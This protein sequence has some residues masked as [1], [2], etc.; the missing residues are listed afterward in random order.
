MFLWHLVQLY[1]TYIYTNPKE[2]Y[3]WLYG[4]FFYKFLILKR[5]LCINSW[6]LKKSE[7][8]GKDCTIEWFYLRC[9]KISPDSFPRGNG[10]V[11]IAESC[12]NLKRRKIK[13]GVSHYVCNMYNMFH[14]CL[15]ILYIYWVIVFSTIYTNTLQ[16]PLYTIQK[17][18]QNH[19]NCSKH[20]AHDNMIQNRYFFMCS[21]CHKIYWYSAL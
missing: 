13:K 14:T 6:S 18:L 9:L 16:I 2:V 3:L 8:I 5:R 21:L 10:T 20:N 15:L 12:P 19:I 4:A 7:M 1:L 11:R 17:E